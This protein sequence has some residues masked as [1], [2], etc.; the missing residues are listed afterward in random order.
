MPLMVELAT[1]NALEVL[2]DE[3]SNGLTEVVRELDA[4]VLVGVVEGLDVDDESTV[5]ETELLTG[6]E[7]EDSPSDDETLELTLRA[8]TEALLELV[9]EIVTDDEGADGR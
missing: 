3:M 9:L 2:L 8:T 4:L 5:L 6:E 7:M 1:E